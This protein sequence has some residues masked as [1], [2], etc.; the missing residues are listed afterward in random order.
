MLFS[1]VAFS[2]ANG[3]QLTKLLSPMQLLHC[4]VAVLFGSGAQILHG[5]S[6]WLC[7]TASSGSSGHMS[8]LASGADELS[9]FY[10]LWVE[11]DDEDFVY[12][13]EQLDS[14]CMGIEWLD[15]IATQPV[16][17]ECF[18]KGVEINQLLPKLAKV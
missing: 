14:Y 6:K 2:A 18:K 13:K 8:L 7:T 16:E 15:F 3:Q 4:L 11:S 12:S 9:F 1:T 10:L 5:L 17:S